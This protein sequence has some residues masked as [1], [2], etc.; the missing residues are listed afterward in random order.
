MQ[1]KMRQKFPF[2]RTNPGYPR[3]FKHYFFPFSCKHK[4]AHTLTDF[5]LFL[6]I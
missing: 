3:A 6:F 1:K 2:A 4:G 5:I